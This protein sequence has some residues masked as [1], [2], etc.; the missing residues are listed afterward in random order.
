MNTRGKRS[1][2]ITVLLIIL[3][4]V[5]GGL[6]LSL[7]AER[8]RGSGKSSHKRGRDREFHLYPPEIVGET[9]RLIVPGDRLELKIRTQIPDSIRE[10]TFY[11]YSTSPLL[12]RF[13]IRE[14]R[15]EPEAGATATVKNSVRVAVDRPAIS[16]LFSPEGRKSLSLDRSVLILCRLSGSDGVRWISSLETPQLK[17]SPARIT[18]P[19]YIHDPPAF[20]PDPPRGEGDFYWR[21]DPGFSNLG[22]ELVR[23][24]ALHSALDGD[25]TFPDSLSKVVHNIY[26]FTARLLEPDSWSEEEIY[27]SKDI[28]RWWE[29]GKIA[30]GRPY[31]YPHQVYTSSSTRPPGYIC[32]EHAY[33]FTSLVRNLGIPARELDVSF[34]THIREKDGTYQLGYYCQEAAAQVYYRGEWHLYDPFL[35]YEGFGDYLQNF[36]AY[37]AWYA[38]DPRDRAGGGTAVGFEGEYGH[39]FWL[40]PDGTGVPEEKEQW[41]HLKRE[42]K[43]GVVVS[44][45]PGQ[46][47]FRL[48]ALSEEGRRTGYG[49]NG[50]IRREISG[51]IYYRRRVIQGGDPEVTDYPDIL[52][53]PLNGET[54]YRIRIQRNKATPRLLSGYDEKTSPSPFKMIFLRTR[55]DRKATSYRKT[56][57]L[58]SGEARVYRLQSTKDG[59]LKI[60]RE[61]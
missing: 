60:K 7:H 39:N 50:R 45:P 13:E 27:T 51:S 28:S 32:L 57:I 29:K 5:A 56:G 61:K 25:V 16:P 4:L 9:D 31:P 21:G 48:L 12:S 2:E 55:N 42:R 14:I 35:E 26:L 15:N 41:K 38:Y 58:Q 52:F 59:G 18:Y 54:T 44:L 30:P 33:L 3:L 49:E 8:E 47:E 23:K 17:G 43:S 46:D 11:F 10:V 19:N 53:L 36:W 24:L 20:L 34:A 37:R 6:S 22:D 1:R 40:A